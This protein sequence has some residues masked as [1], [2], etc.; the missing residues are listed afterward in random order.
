M[1]TWET[2]LKIIAAL[3]AAAGIIFLIVNYGD[4]IVAWAKSLLGKFSCCECDGCECNEDGVCTCDCECDDCDCCDCECDD[5]DCEEEV[6]EPAAEE[7]AE[8]PAAE[9][10]DFEG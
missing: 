4:K 3:A 6:E 1:K 5:C 10:T 7:V 9:E 2:I 8:E